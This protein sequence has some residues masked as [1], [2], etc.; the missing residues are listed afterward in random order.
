MRSIGIGSIIA[1]ICSISLDG[2]SHVESLHPVQRV[3]ISCRL[4]IPVSVKSF[5]S[6]PVL[7]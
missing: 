3:I 5:V 1:L 6:A 7:V 4:L 2:Y